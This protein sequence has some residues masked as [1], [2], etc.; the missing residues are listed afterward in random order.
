MV[1]LDGQYQVSDIDIILNM[2]HVLYLII[3]TSK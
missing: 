3:Y 1:Q 2:P